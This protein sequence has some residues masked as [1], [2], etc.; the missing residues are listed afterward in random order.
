M[1]NSD[2]PPLFFFI[3]LDQ[4]A[5]RRIRTH[6]CEEIEIDEFRCGSEVSVYALS[7]LIGGDTGNGS[8]DSS[9]GGAVSDTT[10]ED[11]LEL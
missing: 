7:I 3:C 10:E 2:I 9:R 11:I 4:L 8:I 5:E 6:I 1:I